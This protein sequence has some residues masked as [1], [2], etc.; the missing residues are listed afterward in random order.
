MI[1]IE[2]VPFDA[3]WQFDRPCVEDRSMPLPPDAL[4]DDEHSR[5]RG[6]SPAIHTASDHYIES[7][8]MLDYSATDDFID[9]MAL[10]RRRQSMSSRCS[11]INSD[12]FYLEVPPVRSAD[13]TYVCPSDCRRISL[14]SSCQPEQFSSP[15]STRTL[16]GKR[17]AIC[18]EDGPNDVTPGSVK[19]KDATPT[20]DLDASCSDSQEADDQ[21]GPT[22]DHPLLPWQ[23]EG[24]RKRTR[25]D[26]TGYNSST[27]T[28]NIGDCS[29]KLVSFIRR[30]EETRQDL[31]AVWHAFPVDSELKTCVAVHNFYSTRKTSESLLLYWYDYHLDDRLL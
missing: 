16:V 31:L 9:G 4:D 22:L 2:P 8:P 10:N 30:S 17:S 23:W 1:I 3:A 20:G 13:Y 7:L 6:L 15:S 11:T 21:Y 27:A 19:L 29:G 28:S 12:D 18:H 26:P 24:E 25:I 5:D 14:E